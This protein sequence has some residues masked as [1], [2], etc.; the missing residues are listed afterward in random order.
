MISNIKKPVFLILAAILIVFLTTACGG[1][2]GDSASAE[3]SADGTE[4]T[5][6]TAAPVGDPVEI[7]FAHL[8]TTDDYRGRA[9]Q[10]FA[11]LCNEMSGGTINISIYPSQSLVTSQNAVKS[12]QTG[13]A[14]MTMSATS[15]SVGEIKDLAPL[16]IHGI[17]D[18][19]YF[20]ETYDAVRPLLNE[21]YETYANQHVLWTVDDT[22]TIFYLT[23][24]NARQVHAPAD[25]AG[26][27]IRDHGTWIGKS[28]SAWGASPMT[29][30]PAD[31]T[32]ALE[33][34][35]VDGGYTGWG[36]IHTYR[37]HEYAPY[38]TFTG[39]GKSSFDP[40]SI[41]LDVWNSMSPEQQA[42]MEDAGR[43]AQELS[44]ELLSEDLEKFLNEVDDF[45]GE[46]YYMTPEETQV[47]VDAIAPL[48]DEASAQ[49]TDLGKQLINALLAAPSQYR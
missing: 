13:V 27:R 18:P 33:R 24:K 39:I 45:G 4:N 17:Y 43:Q 3:A 19:E 6:E 11:D 34:G 14:D 48:I 30:V 26:L 25:I 31:L 37:A 41:N 22:D 40:A 12:V 1:D 16:D 7:R 46:V 38:I 15:W 23:E 44:N 2:A 10:Y 32:V 36:F 29:V 21:I 42:I 28:I 5:Q 49:C 8:Y 47:F 9:I 20:F 35:T